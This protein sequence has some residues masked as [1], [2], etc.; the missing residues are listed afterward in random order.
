MIRKIGGL[1]K[2]E[3]G[4]GRLVIR[5]VNQAGVAK[6]VSSCSSRDPV[7][8]RLEPARRKAIPP[9]AIGHDRCRD[10][11]VDAFGA[12]QHSLH[13]VLGFRRHA[14]AEGARFARSARR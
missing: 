11:A 12:D 14:A 2:G 8:S 13:G 5:D 4:S 3:I 6:V 10:D 9:F 7:L 1:L